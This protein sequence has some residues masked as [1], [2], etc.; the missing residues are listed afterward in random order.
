MKTY[1][2]YGEYVQRVYIDIV[3]P[4]E[5]TA[6]DIAADA[7]LTDWTAINKPEIDITE[8]D[9]PSEVDNA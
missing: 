2:L 9:Y 6:Q 4:D 5:D 8:I 3:A 7:A 1:R